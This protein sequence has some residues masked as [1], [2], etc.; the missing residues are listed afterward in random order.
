MGAGR[1]CVRITAC[2]HVFMWEFTESQLIFL[3]FHD[4][5]WLREAV[6]LRAKLKRS[7]AQTRERM[8]L[9]SLSARATK[10]LRRPAW[11][12]LPSAVRNEF[13]CSRRVRV[14]RPGDYL[15]DIRANAN[16]ESDAGCASHA[17]V[18]TGDYDHDDMFSMGFVPDSAL[19]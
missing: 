12:R 11:L 5:Y 7:L 8:C 2:T 19:R 1:S 15:I 18:C 4:L 3:V 14:E 16:V 13:P 9:L 17:M 10:L 6:G